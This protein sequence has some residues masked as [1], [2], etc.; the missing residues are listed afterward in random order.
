[1][2]KGRGRPPG[3]KNKKE[4]CVSGEYLKAHY[5]ELHKRAVSGKMSDG[6]LLRLVAW[7]H[8]EIHGKA[9]ERIDLEVS[10]GLTI[11]VKIA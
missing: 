11:T 3:A 10:G 1:M 2:A 8:A 4:S 6:D 5:V 7:E 9:K